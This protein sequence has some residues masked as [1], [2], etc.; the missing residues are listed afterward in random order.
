M[1]YY[2]SEHWN[3]NRLLTPD[4]I[5]TYYSGLKNKI[6]SIDPDLHV[7]ITNS[8]SMVTI[9]GAFSLYEKKYSDKVN[10]K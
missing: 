4:S 8:K 1:L 3:N 9:N 10:N 6:R 7:F 5:R 2:Y